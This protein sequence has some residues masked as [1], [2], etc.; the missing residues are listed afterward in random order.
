[1]A[2]T[3]YE[4]EIDCGARFTFACNLTRH[5]KTCSRRETKFD[6]TGNRILAPESAFEKTFYPESSF[7]FKAVC[8]LEYEAKQRGIYIHHQRCGHRGGRTIFSCKV[9]GYYTESETIFQYHGCHWHGCHVCF[10]NPDE[11]AFALSR[12]RNGRE[13]TREDAYQKTQNISDFLRRNGH[14]VIERWEHE[15][16]RPWWNDRCPPKRNETYPHAIVYDFESYQ[17]KTKP[18]QPT[19]DLFLESEHVPISVSIADTLNAEPEYIVARDPNELLRL[20][21]L[22]LERRSGAIRENIAQKYRPPDVEGLSE[23]QKKLIEQWCDH[24]PVLCFNSDMKL[25]RKY[26]VTHLAQES[27]VLAAEKEGR[28]MFIKT[29]RYNFL[30]IMNYMAPVTT[31]DK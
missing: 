25:I 14:T 26:F 4:R 12:A 10:P 8:W 13:I 18:S 31:Y 5:A 9:D 22:A 7:G 23:A 30:D 1:M 29:L 28:I 3:V 17:D 24:L 2:T 15:L 11:R 27:G 6:C 16:P 19:R 20:F 21:Y